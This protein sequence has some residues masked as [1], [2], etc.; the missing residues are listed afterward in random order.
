MRSSVH[1]FCKKPTAQKGTDHIMKIRKIAAPIAL[2][3]AAVMLTA[4]GANDNNGSTNGTTNGSA[5]NSTTQNGVM[6]D[7][8]SGASDPQNGDGNAIGENGARNGAENARNGAD[9]ARTGDI[10]GDGFIEDVVTGAEDIVDDAV[11]GAEDI[12]DDILP[13]ENDNNTMTTTQTR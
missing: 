3:F 10:D 5:N 2:C 8:G 6:G 12:I 11:T 4:C 13:G 1:A 7:S 9:G